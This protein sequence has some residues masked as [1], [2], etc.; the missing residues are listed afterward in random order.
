M[1]V[2]GQHAE[3]GT[4][5][6]TTDRKLTAKKLGQNDLATVYS[7]EPHHTTLRTS[8]YISLR[9]KHHSLDTIRGGLAVLRLT[10][11]VS[12]VKTGP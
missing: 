9:Y 6:S 4:S 8:S 7:F 10:R 11:L 12:H 2:P 1:W 5:W 3:I